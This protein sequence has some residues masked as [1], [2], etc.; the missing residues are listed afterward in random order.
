VPVKFLCGVGRVLFDHPGQ[1]LHFLPK[2]GGKGRGERERERQIVD[3]DGC[4]TD[5]SRPSVLV[6]EVSGEVR[7]W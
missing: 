6:S 2:E 1:L 4:G 3:G 5:R 7:W